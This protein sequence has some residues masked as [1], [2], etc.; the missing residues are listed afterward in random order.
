[1]INFRIIKSL[2][3]SFRIIGPYWF[4]CLTSRLIKFA[5][6]SHLHLIQLNI[7]ILQRHTN[8]Q[9]FVRFISTI[10]LLLRKFSSMKMTSFGLT[11]TD[12]SF[13]YKLSSTTYRYLAH[14]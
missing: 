4:F 13:L 1:M 11:L 10:E 12:K 14:F 8:P 9:N 6:C 2:S 7:K 3:D 5:K